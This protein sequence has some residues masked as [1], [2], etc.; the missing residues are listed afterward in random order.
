MKT[1]RKWSNILLLDFFQEHTETKE[2]AEIVA[3]KHFSATTINE[4]GLCYIPAK[5]KTKTDLIW[6]RL[7][8]PIHDFIGNTIAF[9]GRKLETRASLIEQIYKAKYVNDTLAEAKIQKWHKS[10]WINEPYE[11]S[12]NLFNYHRAAEHMFSENYAIVVE[13]YFDTMGLWDKGIKNVVASCG[14][15]LSK[16][17][18]FLIKAMCDTL[19]IMYD[20]DIRGQNASQTTLEACQQYGLN[21]KLLILPNGQDP[22]DFILHKNGNKFKNMLVEYSTTDTTKIELL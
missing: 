10:K 7:S 17:Q 20:G 6:E 12:K 4:F 9:A 3:S 13:G 2:S 11:K 21:A 5:S 22:D 15:S 14:L 16:Y 18:I 1:M 8:L 19:Y